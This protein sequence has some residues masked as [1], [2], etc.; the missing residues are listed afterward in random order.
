MANRPRA[1]ASEVD[2]TRS[3]SCRDLRVLTG[4]Q[5]TENSLKYNSQ[6]T[7]G[8]LKAFRL[9]RPSYSAGPTD[10]WVGWAPSP[11]RL[12]DVRR[13]LGRRRAG[14]VPS[15][16]LT[17]AVAAA[18]ATDAEPSVTVDTSCR[19]SLAGSTADASTGEASTG[20]APSAACWLGSLASVS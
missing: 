19:S 17:A 16:S 12:R 8:S 13:R 4:W 20:A 15:V 3:G 10:C 2:R 11:G 6:I 7:Q 18:G 9:S 1:V 14:P 5:P